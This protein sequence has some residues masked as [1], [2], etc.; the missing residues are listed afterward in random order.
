VLASLGGA[1]SLV[2]LDEAP[3]GADVLV[4]VGRDF[5]HVAS[6]ATAPPTTAAADTAATAAPTTT[7]SGPA[8]NPGGTAPMPSAGC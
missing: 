2:K 8:A 5:D 3:T 6:P 4:V 7:T 1:G